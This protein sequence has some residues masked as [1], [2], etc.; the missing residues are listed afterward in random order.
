AEARV[1]HAGGAEVQAQEPAGAPEVGQASVADGDQAEVEVLDLGR[2]LQE[3]QV[4]VGDRPV[5]PG[6]TRHRALEVDPAER[7]GALRD[8]VV[9]LAL[10]GAPVDRE[11]AAQADSG[12]GH[13]RGGV[14]GAGAPATRSRSTT[15]ARPTSTTS[16][17]T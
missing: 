14:G 5:R 3:G 1:G 6:M 9:D 4:L 16:A 8:G 13:A 11:P 10:V 17:S 7:Q 2:L 15:A 12:L